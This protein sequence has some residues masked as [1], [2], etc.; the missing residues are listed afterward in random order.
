[1]QLSRCCSRGPALDEMGFE[2]TPLTWSESLAESVD[3]IRLAMRCLGC[4]WYTA[5]LPLRLAF[6][7]DYSLAGGDYLLYSVLDLVYTIF[8]LSEICLSYQLTPGAKIKPGAEPGAEDASSLSSSPSGVQ[9]AVPP[10]EVEDLD[11]DAMP[12]LASLSALYEVLATL[13]VEY[14]A[15]AAGLNSPELPL[16]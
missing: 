2:A 13:P 15:V 8:F 12:P 5:S 11:E 14:I 4:L 10:G 16:M 1:M 9:G 6:L 3:S 7:P